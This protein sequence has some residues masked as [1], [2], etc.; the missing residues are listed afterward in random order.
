MFG[1]P[2]SIFKKKLMKKLCHVSKLLE[3]NDISFKKMGMA[4]HI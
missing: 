3:S 4:G 2:W 1:S